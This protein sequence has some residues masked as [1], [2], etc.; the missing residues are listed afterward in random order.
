MAPTDAVQF[1]PINDHVAAVLQRI[2]QEEARLARSRETLAERLVRLQ[3]EATTAGE[4]V[5]KAALAEFL[6]KPYVVRPLGEDRYE[7]IVPKFIGFR[8]GWPVRTEGAF[9]VFLVSKFIHFINPLPDWLANDLGYGKPAFHATLDGNTLVVDR[10]DPQAIA[11]KLGGSRAIAHR[12]G[13]RLTIKPASRFDLIRRIIRE[14]GFLPF[15]PQPIPDSL[16]RDPDKYITHDEGGKPAFALRP[17]QQRAYEYFLQTGAVSVFAYPQTG[18][19]F[20][21]LYAFADLKGPKIIFCPRRSLVDQWVDRL[22]LYL[23]LEAVAEVTVTTYQSLAKY[24]EREWTLVVPDEAHHLPADFAIEA[25]TLKTVARMGLSATPRREDGNED[26]IPALCGFPVGADWP[27]SAAQR[28]TVTVWIVKN[29]DEKVKLC[30]RLVK[31]PADGKT[32]IFTYRLAIGERVAKSLGIPFVSGKTK[33]P[34]DVLRDNEMVAVS[35]VGNEGLSFPVRRVVEIDFLYGSGME[36]GQR[37]GRLA[38]EVAG[39]DQP[40]EHHVL[41]THDE[42]ARY[43]KRLLIYAQWGLDVDVRSPEGGVSTGAQPLRAFRVARSTDHVRGHARRAATRPSRPAVVESERVESAHEPQDEIARTLALAPVAAKVRVAKEK[44]ERP[45]YADIA[46]RACWAATLSADDI[47]LGLESTSAK[48]IGRIRLACR[49]L[50]AQGLMTENDAEQF[51]VNQNEIQR[52]TALAELS[53]L[54]RSR[55]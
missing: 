29:E 44:I 27:V 7:L 23:T 10:G 32:F 14:E 48:T 50:K 18:K 8:G 36:A 15:T 11:E 43:S 25:S 21:A 13:N 52:L 19:S 54:A 30:R 1:G 35:S 16:R 31:T 6:A 42:Y 34:L 28:P 26:L 51:S 39:K 37:L 3:K 55:R 53:G 9:L 33:R 45:R 24:R 46:L 38:Y 40:G 22:H 12:E 5:D 20:E 4:H 49:A 41:M 17:H 2:E 47:A